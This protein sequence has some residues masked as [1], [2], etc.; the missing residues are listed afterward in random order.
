[1]KLITEVKG[2][3]WMYNRAVRDFEV[4]NEL[5]SED[6]EL[7]SMGMTKEFQSGNIPLIEFIDFFESFND[8]LGDY[9]RIKVQLATAAERLSLTIGKEIF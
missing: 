4:S 2:V 3:L 6:F 9:S 7:T 1:M 5:F 8:A